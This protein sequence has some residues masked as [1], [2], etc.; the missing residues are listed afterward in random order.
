MGGG[1]G[2]KGQPSTSVPRDRIRPS[3]DA[4]GGSNMGMFNVIEAGLPCPNCGAS[5]E[6][7]TKDLSIRNF[8]IE[9]LLFHIYLEPDM[10]GEM[11]TS[12]DRCFYWHEAEI[13]GGK[14]TNMRSEA[15]P[16]LE[17]RAARRNA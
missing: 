8:P 11:Y 12:C 15:Q 4:E 17:E 7:Q 5:V 6:W 14:I 16:D 13:V 1:T 3:S 2:P 10:D 9:N